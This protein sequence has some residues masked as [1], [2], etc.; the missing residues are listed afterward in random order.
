MLPTKFL[1]TCPSSSVEEVKMDFQDGSHGD[2]LVLPTGMILPIFCLQ[3]TPMLTT[4]FHVNWP[5]Y[6][7]EEGKNRYSR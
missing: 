4:K 7:G 2:H 6:S 3:V 5:L 1:V